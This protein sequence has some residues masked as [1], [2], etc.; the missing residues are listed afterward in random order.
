MQENRQGSVFKS[1]EITG[2]AE[3][4]LNVMTNPALAVDPTLKVVAVND[5]FCELL[6]TKASGLKGVSLFNLEKLEWDAAKE[7]EK[8]LLKND[9]LEP[10]SVEI[11]KDDILEKFLVKTGKLPVG[12][13]H[14]LLLSFWCDS[15]EKRKNKKFIEEVMSQAPALICVLKGPNHI[16]EIANEN[17]LELVG[18]RD[19]IGKPVKEALP[20]V[21]SQGFTDIL[22]KVYQTGEAYV[23]TE[24]PV[25]LSSEG[26]SL[27]TRLLDFVYQPIRNEENQ[28]EG[29][30]VHA[31]D[32]TE[33]TSNSRK[34]RE[35]EK[36][37]RAVI[38]TV[39][40]IIWITDEVGESTYLNS[41]WYTYTGQSKEENSKMGWLACVHPEDRE[42]VMQ[43]FLKS[44]ERKESFS[45]FYRLRNKNGEYRWAMDSGRPKYR[46]DGSFEGMIGTVVDIHEDKIK[47]QLIRE[48]EHKISSIIEQ[49]TV[50]TAVYIGEEMK[51]EMANDAMIQLWGKDS[52]VIGKKLHEALPEL[53][54]QPFREL[55]AQ[56]FA[57]G[58]TYWGKEEKVDLQIGGE[59]QT[60]YYNFTY[61]ALRNEKGKIYGIL[62]TALDVTE[63]V[64]VR[65]KIEHSEKRYQDIIMS[66]PYPIATWKGDDHVIEIA[67]EAMIKTWGKGRDVFG[68]P[69]LEVFPELIEQGFEEI[70]QKVYQKGETYRG[71]EMPMELIR[72]GKREKV[73]YSFVYYPQRDIDGNIIGVVDIATEVTPQAELKKKL[74]ESE[75]HYRQMADLMPEK[76]INTDP[77]GRA[78]F[79][80]QNWLEFTGLT[81]D[82]LREKNWTSLIHPKDKEEFLKEW[83]SCLESGEKFETEVRIA[84]REQ[85]YLWHISRA[86]AVKDEKGDITMWIGTNTQIQR[87]KEE[88]KR[89]EDFLKMVSHEL[90]TPVTSIKGY[91]QLLLNLLR[92]VQNPELE[93]LP[94]KVS[95]ERID[96]QIRRLTRLISE[97]LDLS[98][99]EEGKL[100][101]QTQQFSINEL[102]KETI[103]DIVLTNTQH[104]IKVSHNFYCEVL[105]DRD[106]IGQVLINFVTNAIKYSP[107]SQLVRVSIDKA[108]EKEVAIKVEDEGLGIEE[109][110]L[111]NIFKRFFRVGGEKKETYS[112]FGIGLYL[113]QEIIQRHKGRI[114][115]KS[116]KGKGSEF[117]FF[118]SI[119]AQNQ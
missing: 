60:G 91:V 53:D 18:H 118:M 84:D 56:V 42:N 26:D 86:E 48:K 108:G 8:K 47:E 75:L 98:R 105:G 2:T 99:I 119:A 25:K 39:P 50:A 51:I 96:H 70:L 3:S 76:V 45:L 55:L 23:G 19:L 115:V 14:L 112:G 116:E 36:N 104:Q 68:K 33:K 10:L 4:L 87:I 97:M 38:D 65:K 49:A 31:I 73:Y 58:K 35:S 15:S 44:L 20:E 22:D 90:K 101:L 16:F 24:I 28:V 113:A 102:V 32:V 69:L 103:Q 93:N 6:D 59:I 114:E 82:E 21:E 72:H 77:V 94:F 71:Y 64:I 12:E 95:L 40:V 89:K 79:F 80:N 57:S 52:S 100:E 11:T 117:T 83:N 109:E 46:L 30:F 78:L 63:Q 67:N 5:A 27:R 34:I 85:N 54:G 29:I 43:K 110:D 66:S 88:E 7:L 13:E 107:D 106:R 61:K 9:I 74:Q 17:Y 62:N 1:S 41:N 37:L 92:T 81:S 111:K